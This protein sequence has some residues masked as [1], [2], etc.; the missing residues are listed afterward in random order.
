[1]NFAPGSE[2]T[3]GWKDNIFTQQS[4]VTQNYF[5]DL[6]NTWEAPGVNSFSL[7]VLYFIDAQMLAKKR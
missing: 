5:D 2:L 1:W 6:R 4:T 3:L 7:K